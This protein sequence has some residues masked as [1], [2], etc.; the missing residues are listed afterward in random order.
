[1][2]YFCYRSLI[3]P[4]LIRGGKPTP[5]DSFVLA[6]IFCMYNGYMQIRYLSHYADYPAHWVT[7]PRFIAGW[8][9]VSANS[10][11]KMAKWMVLFCTYACLVDTFS[12]CKNISGVALSASHIKFMYVTLAYGKWRIAHIYILTDVE[13]TIII[14]TSG[15]CEGRCIR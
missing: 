10:L 8:C 7:H 3:Y 6:I 11:S 9:L 2:F 15:R 12:W 4:F 13:E 1:M 5:L 14:H